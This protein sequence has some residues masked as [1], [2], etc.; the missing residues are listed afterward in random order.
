M[1]AQEKREEIALHR[2]RV[3]A[4]LKELLAGTEDLLKSTASYTGIEIEA[5]REKLKVQVQNAR[6]SAGQWEKVAREKV[7]HASAVADTYVH[8]N[9]W[10]S[11]GLAALLGLLVGHKL[12]SKPRYDG[13][14]D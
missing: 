2:A 10:K 1:S 5:A 12:Q 4:S 14:A 11:I 8:E 3:A 7:D 9:T 6:E 13:A